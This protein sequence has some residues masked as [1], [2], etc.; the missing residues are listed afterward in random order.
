MTRSIVFYAIIP[1]RRANYELVQ[2]LLAGSPEAFLLVDNRMQRKR[3][4]RFIEVVKRQYSGNV[5]G[6]VTGIGLVNLVRRSGESGNFLPLDFRLYAPAQDGL[7]KNNHFQALFKQVVDAGTIQART[8]TFDSWYA[9]SGN[10]K[11]VERAG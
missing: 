4:S 8:L 9:S 1:F 10:L 6:L 3:Y 11:V 7:T 2:P 5:H